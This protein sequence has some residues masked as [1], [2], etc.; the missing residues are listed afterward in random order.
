[1][2]PKWLPKSK[3]IYVKIDTEKGWKKHSKNIE[4]TMRWILKIIGFPK[5][6][7]TFGNIGVFSNLLKKTRKKSSKMMEESMPDL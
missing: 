5:E 3:K 1:M 4:K 7:P 6:K 2:D